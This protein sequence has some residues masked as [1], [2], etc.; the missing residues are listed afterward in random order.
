M[1]SYS[2]SAKHK[3]RSQSFITPT[4]GHSSL[5][6][7]H[8]LS[9]QTLS[10]TANK[11]CSKT[12][13]TISN[14]HQSAFSNPLYD[15][16]RDD[17]QLIRDFRP[18]EIP[19]ILSNSSP[20]YISHEN[21]NTHS[22]G[23]E[24]LQ[25]IVKSPMKKENQFIMNQ[26]E[27]RFA[28]KE[29]QQRSPRKEDEYQRQPNRV[30]HRQ[31]LLTTNPSPSLLTNNLD[32]HV[33]HNQLNN[34]EFLKRKQT[35]GQKQVD[36]IT[37]VSSATTYKNNSLTR[38]TTINNLDYLKVFPSDNSIKSN[39]YEERTPKNSPK[40]IVPTSIKDLHE[41]SFQLKEILNRVNEIESLAGMVPMLKQKVDNLTIENKRLSDLL[42]KK[43]LCNQCIKVIHQN[44]FTAEIENIELKNSLKISEEINKLNDYKN[45]MNSFKLLKQMGET[46]QK[47]KTESFR[48]LR[49]LNNGAIG[50][51]TSV[52]DNLVSEDFK[53]CLNTITQ[54]MEEEK[55]VLEGEIKPKV[56]Q[57]NRN[58]S[59]IPKKIESAKVDRS[60][61]EVNTQR[62]E[63]VLGNSRLSR[64]TLSL[65][66]S[67]P[68]SFTVDR[69]AKYDKYVESNGKKTNID[70]SNL[71]K[72]I[73]NNKK[74]QPY[75]KEANN[76]S[77]KEQKN[78]VESD[79]NKLK[80]SPSTSFKEKRS[81]FK[82]AND[83]PRM[84]RFINS[85]LDKF[86]LSFKTKAKQSPI[87]NETKIVEVK[88]CQV[89]TEKTLD[90]RNEQV[91]STKPP[92]TSPQSDKTTSNDPLKI[93]K[94]TRKPLNDE[95][96]IIPCLESKEC[97]MEGRLKKRRR[98]K[99][100][101]TSLTGC[102]DPRLNQLNRLKK[103]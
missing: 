70:N 47:V 81:S 31:N 100:R 21:N 77:E 29:E 32:D 83:Q 92:T 8:V 19:D 41:I 25:Q 2:G 17:E 50:E 94:T 96:V 78:L 4:N 38:D 28:R 63:E 39:G 46:D 49:S 12:N 102:R 7:P 54:N 66:R 67:L 55:V 18:H 16:K 61:T 3:Y 72:N 58:T 42:E 62:N 64:R 36:K 30:L 34:F 33:F 99:M 43:N 37:P 9:R 51:F 98:R 57:K 69:D 90:L 87:K 20:S 79:L 35:V 101:S 48:K 80:S 22:S 60:T 40:K 1:R 86:S 52:E 89:N 59:G 74:K 24:D 97:T 23:S 75:K 10:P 73:K 45:E 44:D 15:T 95:K 26:E 6:S 53:T 14:R 76:L 68:K 91:A 65:F 82:G 84:N 27:Q 71:Y 103:N 93:H 13:I 85:T 11:L 5:Q 88:K 56:K